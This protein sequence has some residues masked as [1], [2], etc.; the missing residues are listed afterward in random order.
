MPLTDYPVNLGL[1]DPIPGAVQLRF[2]SY[3]NW[4]QLPTPPDHFT[5]H[6][7][8]VGNWGML[9][10]GAALD[11]PPGL[12]DGVGDCAV[13]GPCHQVMKATAESGA[14]ANFDTGAA[15]KNYGAI[16]GWNIDDPDSDA[17]TNIGDMAR[18][19]RK[20]GLVDAAGKI[21]KIVAYVDLNPGDIR[22]LWLAAWI[23]PL[24]VGCGYALPESALEQAQDGEIWD[25]VPGSP[26]AGGHYVPTLARPAASLGAGV[27]WGKLRPFTARWHQKYNNQGIVPLST[28]GLVKARSLE[29]FDL[30]TLTD[31]L[32]EVTR[33]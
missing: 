15:L 3:V 7:D 25:V 16:T 18:Y 4:R 6:T 29:G 14:I 5:G 12:P 17:G 8:L 13:A 30:P 31:D 9:G 28:E 1:R 22:E 11:N 27:S 26:I 32:K 19:W 21:H 10:N 24:G 20:H 23:F 33:V 2:A